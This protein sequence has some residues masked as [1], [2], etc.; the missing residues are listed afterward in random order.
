MSVPVISDALIRHVLQEQQRELAKAGPVSCACPETVAV[1]LKTLTPNGWCEIGAIRLQGAGR[2]PDPTWH[3]VIWWD[4]D[5]GEV[6]RTVD[7]GVDERPPSGPRAAQ[8]TASIVMAASAARRGNPD[9]ES[10]RGQCSTRA[11][12]LAVIGDGGYLP[13]TLCIHCPLAMAESQ[14]LKRLGTS[15]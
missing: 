3:Y 13:Q 12:T 9:L 5:T 15:V 1:V 7:G 11:T 10:T 2:N 14:V 8:L 6:R 4:V